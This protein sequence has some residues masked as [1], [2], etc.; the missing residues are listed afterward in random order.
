MLQMSQPT[1]QIEEEG[2]EK[3]QIDLG[4][5][6]RARWRSDLQRYGTRDGGIGLPSCPDAG[7]PRHTTDIHLNAD[8]I[9][10]QTKGAADVG[11]QTIT[12]DGG[13]NSGWHTHPGFVLAVLQKGSVSITVG[14]STTTYTVGQSFYETGTTPTIARNASATDEA[15][16]R[17]TYIVPKG[18]PTRLEVLTP[19]IPVC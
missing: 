7:A 10:F 9:K 2:N 13:G 16:V 8:R 19:Q 6:D 4:R 18:S 1:S 15:I 17:A 12:V 3:A 5:G 11:V 14:C